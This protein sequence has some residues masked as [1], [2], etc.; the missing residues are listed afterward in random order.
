MDT[1]AETINNEEDD[2]QEENVRDNNN[3]SESGDGVRRSVRNRVQRMTIKADDIGD[4]DT[5]NDPDYED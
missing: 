5:E 3:K 1:K 4:C 2:I